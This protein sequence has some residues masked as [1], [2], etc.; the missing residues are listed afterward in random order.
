MLTLDLIQ[1]ATDFL[2]GRIRETPLEFSHEL[3]ALLGVPVWLKLECL[4]LTGSF[5]IRGAYFKLSKLN[6]A[7]KQKG[8]VTC[9]GGNHGKGIAYAAEKLGIEAEIH[10][11]ST[12][13]E[14]K[15][16][17]MLALGAKV[18]RSGFK[19]FD[20]TEALAKKIAKQTGKIY[21][22]AFE[23]PYIMAGN[24][25]SLAQEV[26]QEFSQAGNFLFPLGGGGLGAGFS[27]FMK[28]KNPDCQIVACQHE[29]SAAFYESLKI[30]KAITVLPAIDTLAGGLEG[31]M[32][33]ENFEILKDRIDGVALVSEKELKDAVVWMLD[34][35][36]YLIEPTGAAALAAVL[37]KKWKPKNTQPV[38]IVLTGRNF[39]TKALKSLFP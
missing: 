15:Y 10:V 6:S 29:E 24:G 11:P 36:Q 14:S 22:S 21:V 25:G 7:E 8:V 34:K 32:G 18:V 17:G 9:S 26:W 2:R 12:V 27:F 39:S 38:V 37:Y 3:S 5:K 1:E 30:G 16:Q 19:G 28:H 31:G 20:D 4:Q 13:D 33:E 23:D 35:H